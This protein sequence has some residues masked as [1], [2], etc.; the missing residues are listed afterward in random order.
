MKRISLYLKMRVLGALE[1]A[2]DNSLVARYK[3]VSQMTFKDED[4]KPHQF[5]WRTIQT[6]WYYYRRHGITEPPQRADKGTMRKVSPEFLLEVIEKLLPSFHGNRPRLPR[7]HRTG[8]PTTRANRPKHLPPKG[9]P[10]RPPQTLQPRADQ[11][12]A[13]LRQSPRQRNV[14]S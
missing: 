12:P 3:A 9:Q 8:P 1:Y 2:P 6:W 14:A 7:P 4:G 13:S 11:A 5:T 10:I